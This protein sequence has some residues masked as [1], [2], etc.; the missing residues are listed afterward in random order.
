MK[1]LF[2]AC[3]GA[4]TAAVLAATPAVA[5]KSEGTLRIATTDWWGTLD[6]Y[7]F[8]LDVAA[9]FYRNVYQP[10]IRYD[11]RAHKFVPCLAT[12]WKRIDPKTV[13][14]TLREGVKFSNG[15]TFDADDVVWTINY[16]KDPK[17]RLRFKDRYDWVDKVEK[18]G[19]Y[20][21]RIVS[22]EA[23]AL[24]LSNIA[25]RFMIYNSKVAKGFKNMAE[26]GRDHPVTTGPYM[27][28]SLDRQKMVL[29]QNPHFWGGKGGNAQ[30]P[31]PVKKVVVF[32]IPD[33]Q[34]QVAQFLSGGIDVI[35]NVPA[36]TARELKQMPGTQIVP[37]HLGNLMYV[38]LDAA[39][40]SGKLMT[41]QRVRKAFMMAVDRPLLAKTVIPGGTF[42]EVL[43]AACIPADFGCSSTTKPPAYDPEGAKKLLAEAGYP[44]GVD[45]DFYVHQPIKE[46]GE[47]IAGQVRAVGFRAKVHPLPLA[48]Y[49]RMRGA[50]KFTA[51]NGF[52][53]TSAQPDVDNLLDFFFDGNRD[54]WKDPEIK[55]IQEKA[56]VEFDDE[57]RAAD[58]AEAMDIINKKNYILPVTDLP[59]V[60]VTVKDVQIKDNPLSPIDTEIG[61]LSWK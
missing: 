6:P 51:F 7:Y 13:E 39:G 50:G 29:E 40:R 33:R 58:L 18:L 20:K 11:E 4:V 42:A 43:D 57:K 37:T 60:F 34:T 24:D 54:Y 17:V 23:S 16:I 10:L 25:Y 8:P 52:Y 3:L 48:L 32:H 14:F 55:K 9:F 38:T 45:M 27:V 2:A 31:A 28:A 36:D 41:D 12:S 1:K 35:R 15:D 53:P 46:I 61:D 59:I 5:Q 21:V 19:S 26:Y 22:K 49:V 47:A 30:F 44:N 56:H